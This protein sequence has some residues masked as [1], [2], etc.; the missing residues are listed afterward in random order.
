MIVGLPVC[1]RVL[2][3]SPQH[4]THARYA[5]A[6]LQGTGALP[7]LIPPLGEAMLGLLDTLDGLLLT[8]SPSNVH[9]GRYGGGESETP[10]LHDPARDDTT[11]PLIR[12]AIA[13]AIPILAICRGIQELNVALGGTLA[14][15]VHVLPGRLDHR[16]HGETLAQR[17]RPAHPITATGR[18]ATIIGATDI[19]VNSVHGQA[20]D[21]PAPG[22]VV[23]AR[24][25]DG[26][27]EAVAMPEAPG[28]VLGVQWHPEWCFADN[29]HS[30]AIFRAFGDACRQRRG[31]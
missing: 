31:R 14:Q 9:P 6:V 12:G 30:V 3:G 4:Q 23:E 22:L 24:A 20:I 5:E 16:G 19:V 17:Y 27:I 21:R 13:R 29:P 25:P 26:T 8:G 7:V 1:T 2:N 18:L 11:L 10:E 28:W 15:R